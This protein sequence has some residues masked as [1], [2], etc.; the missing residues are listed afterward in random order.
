MGPRPGLG[1]EEENRSWPDIEAMPFLSGET[2]E[3]TKH[4]MTGVPAKIRTEP[5]MNARLEC[6]C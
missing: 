6:Y 5:L 1:I 3:D 4:R 2:K